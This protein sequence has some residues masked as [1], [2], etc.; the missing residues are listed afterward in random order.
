[1]S[2]LIDPGV[3]HYTY[4]RNENSKLIGVN[5]FELFYA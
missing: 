4:T 2:K 3:Q 1:M 5:I